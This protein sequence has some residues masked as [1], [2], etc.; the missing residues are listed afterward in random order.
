MERN[1][2]TLIVY[3][4]VPI[5]LTVARW[6]PRK[7]R[8]L[9]TV[10]QLSLFTT[11]ACS[12]LPYATN[13]AEDYAFGTSNYCLS[14][15]IYE[16]SLIL[17]CCVGFI[18]VLVSLNFFVLSDPYKEHW[19]TTRSRT[20][21]TPSSQEH[22]AERAVTFEQLQTNE[23]L[24]WF[25]G[26]GLETRGVGWNWQ[27]PHLPPGPPKGIPLSGYL[28]RLALSLSKLYLIHDFSA[29]L[30]A[31]F[32]LGGPLSL[33]ELDVLRRNAAV[34]LFAFSNLTLLGILYELMCLVGAVSGLFWTQY[35]ENVPLFGSISDCFTVGRF[36]G[37]V[38]HQNTRRV[39]LKLRGLVDKLTL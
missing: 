7:W 22:Q 24:A 19:W 31:S 14:S 10:G 11:I 27:I 5:E 2:F 36:W 20:K 23:R 16:K 1:N 39:C 25:F 35:H 21:E 17:I 15:Q 18:S 33:K 9:F 13:P 32:T 3:L 37:R 12:A 38:W 29:T 8:F 34:V 6:C 28:K 4:L 26:N 30:L